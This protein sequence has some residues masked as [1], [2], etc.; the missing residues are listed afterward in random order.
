MTEVSEFM[1]NANGMES[2]NG[3]ENVNGTVN[4]LT[5]KKFQKNNLLVSLFSL[6]EAI[7]NLDF[8]LHVIIKWI[9]NPQTV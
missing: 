9:Y 7:C 5:Q 4:D 8:N 2:G 1:A 3:M 6:V